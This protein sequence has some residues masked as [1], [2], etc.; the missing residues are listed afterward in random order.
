MVERSF[1]LRAHWDSD[2]KVYWAESD[3]VPGLVTE[4]ATFDQLVANVME[5][6]PELLRL[7][8]HPRARDAELPIQVTIDRQEILRL[9]A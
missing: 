8:D 2:A 6:V 9:S 7:N 1:T 5:L 3:D 4:S